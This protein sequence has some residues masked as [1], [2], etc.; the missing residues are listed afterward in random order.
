MLFARSIKPFEGSRPWLRRTPALWR[1]NMG[2]L[3]CRGLRRWC[4]GVRRFASDSLRAIRAP[5]RVPEDSVY[6][7]YVRWAQLD[8]HAVA[9]VD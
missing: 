5:I 8:N 4:D 9:A 7:T 6:M 2:R 1:L 3:R